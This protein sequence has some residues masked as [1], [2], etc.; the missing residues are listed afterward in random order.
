MESVPETTHPAD[1]VRVV[2]CPRPFGVERVDVEMAAGRTIGEM[3]EE[4]VGRGMMERAGV[5][6]FV[7]DIPV[8]PE[9]FPRVRPKAG[10]TVTMRVVARG[11]GDSEKN[12]LRTVLTI[13]VI[14]ASFA[15]G[16]Y[17]AGLEALKGFTIGG[18]NIA[19]A[20]ASGLTPICGPML[21][22]TSIPSGVP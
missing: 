6:V 16:G 12:T 3:V 15:V 7:G 4:I 2:A 13:A 8:P 22:N 14:A 1:G 9:Y 10:Q 17:V 19:G 5:H 11:G 21:V 18:V 20:F